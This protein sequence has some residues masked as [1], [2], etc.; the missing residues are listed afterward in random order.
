MERRDLTIPARVLATSAHA[1]QQDK[2]GRPYIEHPARVAALVAQDVGPRHA[3]VAVAWLHDVVEDTDVT[4]E[5]IR[6][7]FGD[8]I[9]A[10]VDA[11]TRR[12]GEEPDAYYA[13]VRADQLALAVK[14]ADIADN[15]DPARVALLDH[16]TATRLA[17]KYRHARA[18]LGLAS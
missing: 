8:Q 6:Q 17:G 5:Q 15:T 4:L 3:A 9:A 12:S 16:A 11:M 7:A 14:R 13:R 18:E 1:G 2:A 10:G